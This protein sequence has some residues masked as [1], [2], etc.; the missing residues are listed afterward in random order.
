MG[1]ILLLKQQLV[2]LTIPSIMDMD[3]VTMGM[4]TMDTTL[5]RDLLLLSHS[6]VTMAITMD[7]A[8]MVMVTDIMVTIIMAKEKHLLSQA[9][10]MDT[11]DT[12]DMVTMDT[13][14]TLGITDTF[15]A[16]EQQNLNPAMATMATMAMAM[17]M[18]IMDTTDITMD[19]MLDS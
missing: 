9:I 16:K 18:V 10:T 3:M 4:A 8:I 7:I 13:M 14:D 15:M 19:R 12:M 1:E 2:L 17:V 11:M 6:M 5:A